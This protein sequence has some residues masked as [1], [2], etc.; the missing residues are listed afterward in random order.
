MAP[1]PLFFIMAVVVTGVVVTVDD[2]HMKPAIMR[3]TIH[4]LLALVFVCDY[5]RLIIA[6]GQLAPPHGEWTWH[7]ANAHCSF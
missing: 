4:Q 2:R 1:W 6:P 7:V 5:H 3:D